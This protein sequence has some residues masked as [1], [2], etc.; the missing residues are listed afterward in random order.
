M[1]K[2]EQVWTSKQVEDLVE[3]LISHGKNA[4]MTQ[5]RFVM[6]AKAKL[7]KTSTGKNFDEKQII[8]KARAVRKKFLA[9]GYEFP[10]IPRKESNQ[11]LLPSAKINSLATQ[12][13]LKRL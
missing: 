1:A 8:A 3:E 9:Q 12:F 2:V 10:N 5:T 4:N 6:L 11:S 7:G 13:K